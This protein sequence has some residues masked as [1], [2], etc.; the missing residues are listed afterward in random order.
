M[1]VSVSATFAS[2]EG[3]Y[4]LIFNTMDQEWCLIIC[5]FYYNTLYVFSNVYWPFSFLLE[6]P[7]WCPLPVFYWSVSVI[8]CSLLFIDLHMLRMLI[9][10]MSYLLQI[11][12]QLFAFRY[13]SI[14]EM[15][16]FKYM[17]FLHFSFYAEEPLFYSKIWK[18]NL[19][20]K[21]SSR[22]FMAFFLA[23]NFLIFLAEIYFN[24]C[25]EINM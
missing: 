25:S 12:S 20:L 10:Y 16:N 5:I 6:L 18:I 4:H 8:V 7:A 3:S 21:F 14:F 15:L 17:G 9:F 1:R 13:R 24:I 19:S 22:F 2:Y 11:F 23:L